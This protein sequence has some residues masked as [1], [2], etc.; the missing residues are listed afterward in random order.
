MASSKH[1]TGCPLH[2]G[3]HPSA[4]DRAYLPKLD[5]VEPAVDLAAIPPLLA[6]VHEG[7]P[8]RAH[9]RRLTVTRALPPVT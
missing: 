3:V 6:E 4:P 8:A 1:W 9:T 2:G 7:R 5:L